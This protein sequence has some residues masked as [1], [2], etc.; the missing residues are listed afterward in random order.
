MAIVF[1]LISG[2]MIGYME[3]LTTGEGPRTLDPKDIGLAAGVQYTIRSAFSALAGMFNFC[4]FDDYLK[5]SSFAN[6]LNIDSIFVII[7]STL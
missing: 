5:D 1:S 4:D 3:V 6:N 7:V 2:L